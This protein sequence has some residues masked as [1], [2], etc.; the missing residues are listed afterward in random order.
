M[1][2]TTKAS[3]VSERVPRDERSQ[4][5]TG[6]RSWY[7]DKR[8]A[9]PRLRSL[10]QGHVWPGYKPMVAVC[11]EDGHKAVGFEFCTCGLYATD[12]FST[13]YMLGYTW[14]PM[15]ARP[16]ALPAARFPLVVGELMLWG[17]VLEAEWG[18]RATHAYPRVLYL[19]RMHWRLATPLRE[20]YGCVV[21]LVNPF[22][23]EREVEHDEDR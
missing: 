14:A 2:P 10:T 18:F 3:D 11:K 15:N 17:T 7:V 8:Y 5:F 6:W 16:P 23:M 4:M 13:L 20:R 22:D 9:G 19:P 12:T 1:T 21:K